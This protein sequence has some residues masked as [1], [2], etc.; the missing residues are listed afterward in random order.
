MAATRNRRRAI[1]V[2]LLV[3]SVTIVGVG[4]FTPVASGAPTELDSCTAITEPGRY[5]LGED[6]TNATPTEEAG[7][8]D[9]RACIVVRSSDVT[10]DGAGRTIDAPAGT[11]DAAGV[12]V[13]N[14]ER[15]LTNVT[16]R[17]LTVTDWTF[18][19]GYINATDG[20]I[21]DTTAT[22]NSL[23]GIEA[24]NADRTDFANNTLRLNSV[25]GLVLAADS[26]D[27]VLS[28]NTASNNLVAGLAVSEAENT[29][30]T[31]NLAETNGFAGIALVNASA[32]CS[33]NR[34]GRR[35]RPRSPRGYWTSRSCP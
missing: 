33:R 10:F 4:S 25:A 30:L 21:R 6:L 11:A 35:S 13:T 32:C 26:E 16:V 12:V 27:A 17:R 24:A 22:S 20:A 23:S 9:L 3:L 2:T 34:S 5:V 31:D 15:T 29:T 7:I 14:D 8:S 19:I 28:D 18:G 1:R